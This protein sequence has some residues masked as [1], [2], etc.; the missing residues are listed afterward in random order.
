M[1]VKV[2]WTGPGFY[3]PVVENDETIYRMWDRGADYSKFPPR[4]AEYF[5]C[6]DDV[7]QWYDDAVLERNAQ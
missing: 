3:A 4:E 6:E 7:E 1:L 2:I 5:A